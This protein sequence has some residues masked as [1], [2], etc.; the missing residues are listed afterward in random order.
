MMTA[1]TILVTRERTLEIS[2]EMEIGQSGKLEE[3]HVKTCFTFARR[4]QARNDTIR[5]A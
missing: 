3:T 2:K 1:S 5:S 4:R